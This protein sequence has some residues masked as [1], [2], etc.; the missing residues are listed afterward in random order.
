M[1]SVVE[2]WEKKTED[3]MWSRQEGGKKGQRRQ[4]KSHHPAVDL[5]VQF[6]FPIQIGTWLSS[7]VALPAL[8]HWDRPMLA[9]L[10]TLAML[11]HALP[12]FSIGR[13]KKERCA[14]GSCVP[15]GIFGRFG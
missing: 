6:L 13:S 10:A 3:R 2:R 8:G 5:L 12:C 14:G 1:T 9:A 11:C 7:V 15:R 4:G